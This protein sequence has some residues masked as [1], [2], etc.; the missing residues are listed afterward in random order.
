M[1]RLFFGLPLPAQKG[2]GPRDFRGSVP[3]FACHQCSGTGYHGRLLLAEL[4]TVDDR[5]RRAIL[6]KSDTTTL[7]GA[8]ATS[9]QL[10]IWSAADSTVAAALTTPEEIERVLGPRSNG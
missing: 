5:L 8:A 9:G 4:L 6:A 2:D 7:E 3:F 1:V 10:G